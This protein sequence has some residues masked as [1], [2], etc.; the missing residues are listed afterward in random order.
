MSATR[1]LSVLVVEDEQAIARGL[2]DVLAFHGYEPTLAATGDEGLREGLSG[3]HDL[4]VLDVML[5]GKS[6]FEVCEELRASLPRLPILL[7][8]A[9]GAE[10][11][12]L[13]GFR[14]GS[15]D[16]VTKPF[17]VSELVARVE[18][19][20]R[21]AGKLDRVVQGPFAFGAWQVDPAAL[22]ARRENE[23][24][25]LTRREADM[26]ALLVRERGRIVSRRTLLQ[27]V[28]GFDSPER[29]ETRTVDMHVA[30]LRK[31]LGEGRDGLLETV[32]GEG[33]R[34]A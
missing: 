6:G 15:D 16:Y 1:R 5:P 31:K 13:R 25:E 14:A 11:D 7:L 19:L 2:A 18:A 34:L 17:S 30:K 8:T 9:R 28:W 24:V 10:E 21:R 3:R 26:L 20:L 33:Y 4:V 29:I 27:E 22:V 32:R 23:S 12:V